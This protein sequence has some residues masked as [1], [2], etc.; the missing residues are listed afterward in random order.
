MIR[1]CDS[2]SLLWFFVK[3]AECMP[4]DK[5]GQF[6]KMFHVIV[7]KKIT[8][9]FNIPMTVFDGQAFSHFRERTLDAEPKS[10]R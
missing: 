10:L 9:A 7:Y 2:D 6:Y 3:V 1:E 4:A 5:K 8:I